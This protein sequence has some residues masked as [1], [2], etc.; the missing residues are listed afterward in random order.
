[1]DQSNAG[2]QIR[3]TYEEYAVGESR[4]GVISDPENEYAW[5][6]SDQVRPLTP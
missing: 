5:I 2:P 3:E 6:W 1:M 4:V